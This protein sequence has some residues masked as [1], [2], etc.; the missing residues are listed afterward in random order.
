M[1]TKN[2]SLQVARFALTNLA[3]Q[4]QWARLAIKLDMTLSV[5]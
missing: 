4:G 1:E 2:V 5:D 3:N